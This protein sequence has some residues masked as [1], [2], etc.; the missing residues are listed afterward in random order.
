MHW[1]LNATYVGLS[2]CWLNGIVNDPLGSEP[3]EKISDVWKVKRRNV[4]ELKLV[5]TGEDSVI[6]LL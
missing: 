1:W 6:V 2:G 3:E 4:D 5:A